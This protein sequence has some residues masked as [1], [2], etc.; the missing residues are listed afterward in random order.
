VSLLLGKEYCEPTFT[1]VDAFLL[2][3]STDEE[4]PSLD[5]GARRLSA[6]MMEFTPVFLPRLRRAL[7]F[8]FAFYGAKGSF[9]RI[10]TKATT[11]MLSLLNS[12]E[13]LPILSFF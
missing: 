9:A 2:L 11:I 8:S 6:S 7:C 13:P 5:F 4:A 3:L 10:S 1:R 12:P